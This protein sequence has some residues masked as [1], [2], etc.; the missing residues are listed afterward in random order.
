MERLA[1]QRPDA[2]LVGSDPFLLLQREELV[3]LTGRLRIPAV[4][5]FNSGECGQLCLSSASIRSRPVSLR[6]PSELNEHLELESHRLRCRL[7]VSYFGDGIWTDWIDEH[8]NDGCLGRETRATVPTSSA[9]A[10]PS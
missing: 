1:E 4:Y 8:G 7:H 5:P 2:L 9:P 10:V 6:A 3:A